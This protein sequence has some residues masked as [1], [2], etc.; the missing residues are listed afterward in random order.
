[1]GQS[2]LKKLIVRTFPKRVMLSRSKRSATNSWRVAIK[3]LFTK[4]AS[5]IAG[6]DTFQALQLCKLHL[7]ISKNMIT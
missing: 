1:M 2:L 5:Q 4:N 7:I 3:E 6:N